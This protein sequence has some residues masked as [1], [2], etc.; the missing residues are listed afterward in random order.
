[1]PSYLR[2]DWSRWCVFTTCSVYYTCGNQGN[3]GNPWE[4]PGL[5]LKTRFAKYINTEPILS[6]QINATC[7]TRDKLILAHA[8][9]WFCASPHKPTGIEAAYS[10]WLRRT[11]S[12]QQLS[13]V[14]KLRHDIQTER[15]L[16]CGSL[17]H[18][19][20]F[21]YLGLNKS[22]PVSVLCYSCVVSKVESYR[23]R[24]NQ[25]KS[26]KAPQAPPHCL[27]C[28]MAKAKFS[29]AMRQ[30]FHP[31][32]YYSSAFLGFDLFIRGSNVTSL[33]S[34]A[35]S[36]KVGAVISGEVSTSSIFHQQ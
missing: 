28:V 11:C 8:R 2:S 29:I 33:P 13:S 3:E 12:P 23:N 35:N 16:V 10:T 5:Y 27:I 22:A 7:W 24:A 15:V 31:C 14:E 26:I 9:K 36:H 1:M 6:I 17:Y 18:E 21:W 20:R 4:K 32:I 30:F 19:K 34:L 25:M